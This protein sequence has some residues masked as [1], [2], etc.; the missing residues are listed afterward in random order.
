MPA[1]CSSAAGDSNTDL[2]GLSG[3]AALWLATGFTVSISECLVVNGEDSEGIAVQDDSI[4][5]DESPVCG[6]FGRCGGSVP[7]VSHTPL[8]GLIGAVV[9][10]V[11]LGSFPN[12][13]VRTCGSEMFRLTAGRVLRLSIML[14]PVVGVIRS[15]LCLSLGVFVTIILESMSSVVSSVLL[16]CCGVGVSWCWLCASSGAGSAKRVVVGRTSS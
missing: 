2:G 1:G 5:V 9:G 12:C 3:V 8:L 4:D 13:S 7:S 10:V 16:S 11:L 6:V 15:R 14:R